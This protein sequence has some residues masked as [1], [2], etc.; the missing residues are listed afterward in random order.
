M[1][2]VE[3]NTNNKRG[4]KNSQDNGSAQQARSP[5]KLRTPPAAFKA[6]QLK[7]PVMKLP[8]V[9]AQSVPFTS[10]ALPL[11]GAFALTAD[12]MEMCIKKSKNTA[13]RLG[14][15][16]LFDADETLLVYPYVWV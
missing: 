8:K 1:E 6:E 15:G 10:K 12:G 4:T 11:Y 2:A 13:I 9:C 14:D 7:D 16:F 5:R 3:T